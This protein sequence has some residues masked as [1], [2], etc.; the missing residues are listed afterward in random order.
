[1][2]L[3]SVQMK[4][5][6]R[7]IKSWTLNWWPRLGLLGMI[8]WEKSSSLTYLTNKS[9]RANK[10]TT[11]QSRTTLSTSS[12]K[13]ENRITLRRE[14]SKTSDNQMNWRKLSKSSK[15]RPKIIPRAR[16]YSTLKQTGPMWRY[17]SFRRLEKHRLE[18][19]T[20]NTKIP[21]SFHS[22]LIFVPNF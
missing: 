14:N 4:T 8:N 1:M 20:A 3:L 9:Q 16:L 15:R 11:S 13:G 5:I 6:T 2:G 7:W 21:N 22:P 18:F 10:A 17:N 12:L 19:R